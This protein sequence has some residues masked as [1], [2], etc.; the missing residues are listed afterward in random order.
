MKNLILDGHLD[1]AWN[2]LAFDRDVTRPLAEIRR[3]DRKFEGASRGRS[4][5]SLVE[6]RRGGVGLCLGTLLAR[7]FN[8]RRVRGRSRTHRGVVLRQSIDYVN[9]DA[10]S[11]VAHGQLA[12]YRLLQRRGEIVLIANRGQLDKHWKSWANA[13]PAQRMK[14]PVGVV[15]S[16]EGADPI[17]D[18]ADA[19]SWWDAGLRTLCLAHYG[20]SAY[21]MG[22]G[23]DGPLTP[24][25]KRLVRTL[26]KLGYALDLVH[27]ADRAVSQCLELFTGNVFVS[28]ANSRTLVPGDRQLSDAQVR[29]IAERQGV[30]G[31]A[32][33]DPMLRSKGRA[34]LRD[35]ADHID[36]F[37]QLLGQCKSVGIGSD[38]DG[39]FGREQTPRGLNSIADLHKLGDLLQPRGYPAQDLEAILHG[40]F[41][42]FLRGA[43]PTK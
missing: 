6:M 3:N 4:T 38:L 32:L 11:A 19:A 16:M 2:A 14:L 24:R 9:Q 39:G 36:H 35:V 31:I 41:L 1:L 10:A 33:F 13:T 40:N 12:Y 28:H 43:M 27:T 21:A 34:T 20:W 37:C 15:L 42:R 23:G 22:T 7:A 26:D 17:L 5:V 8:P 25:G 18:E 30:I 29:A